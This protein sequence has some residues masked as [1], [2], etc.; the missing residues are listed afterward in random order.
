M[1]SYVV[2]LDVP[3]DV[4]VL[5]AILKVLWRRFGVKCTSIA[6]VAVTTEAPRPE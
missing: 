2:R 4:H 1:P 6:E 5:R 3:G